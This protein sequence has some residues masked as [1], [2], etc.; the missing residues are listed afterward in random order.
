MVT[1]SDGG[2]SR[3]IKGTTTTIETEKWY[4]IAVTYDRNAD[5]SDREVVL[6]IKE[7]TDSIY[8]REA[9][10]GGLGLELISMEILHG[11]LVVDTEVLHV[12]V[13][14]TELLTN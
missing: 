7:E 4:C 9:S 8:Q 12:L 11:L 2:E 6:Y 5:G 13:I 3:I 14:L 1:A 10:S